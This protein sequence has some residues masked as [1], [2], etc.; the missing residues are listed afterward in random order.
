[1][2]L[3]QPQDA[4]LREDTLA[5][6]YHR[7]GYVVVRRLLGPKLVAQ[8]LSALTDLASG[9]QPQ[10]QAGILYEPG[11]DAAR[12]A[13]AERIDRV[14]KFVD[15]V[16]DFPPS[17]ARRC[18]GP[19]TA[20]STGC[21]GGPRAVPGDGAGQAAAHRLSQAVAPGCL[22]FPRQRPGDDRRRVDRARCRYA[23]KRLHWRWCPARIGAVRHP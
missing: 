13:A 18:C 14:R 5:A 17:S 12:I 7:D 6:R 4:G 10:G 15:F 23:R 21:W 8:C 2:S 1:M 3:S 20:C 11:Q 22:L 9:Q 16:E 19:C